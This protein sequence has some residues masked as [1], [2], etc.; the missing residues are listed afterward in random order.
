[1]QS[2]NS[3]LYYES[4]RICNVSH[5]SIRFPAEVIMLCICITA[6][7]DYIDIKS[8]FHFPNGSMPGDTSCVTLNI[9]D[10]DLIEMTEQFTMSLESAE[11][12]TVA[13]EN[14]VVPVDIEDNDGMIIINFSLTMCN[15]TEVRLEAIPSTYKLPYWS[16]WSQVTNEMRMNEW[17]KMVGS[18][19]FVLRETLHMKLQFLI[20]TI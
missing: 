10:D 16:D 19:G 20:H 13:E 6:G 14:G 2:Q 11:A 15:R 7:L 9:Q 3:Y 17:I 12:V 1:M 5:E 18:C 8:E 4:V